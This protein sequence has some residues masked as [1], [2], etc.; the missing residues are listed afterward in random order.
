MFGENCRGLARLAWF[1]LTT[2]KSQ[3]PPSSHS[4]LLH[5]S[6]SAAVEPR[7]ITYSFSAEGSTNVVRIIKKTNSVIFLLKTLLSLN[8]PARGAMSWPRERRRVTC[9][10]LN[11]FHRTLPEHK[12]Q[13]NTGV[14]FVSVTT[15]T[16]IW[17]LCV[18]M[19]S[20]I[21]PTCEQVRRWIDVESNLWMNR[22]RWAA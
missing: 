20:F 5:S 16:G 4:S 2:S 22:P 10:C 1:R 13:T 14:S 11:C 6:L 3:T 9:P 21:S 18:C 15:V 7:H 17:L 19:K 12:C 8:K